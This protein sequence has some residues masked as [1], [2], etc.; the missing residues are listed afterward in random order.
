MARAVLQSDTRRLGGDDTSRASHLKGACQSDQTFSRDFCAEAGLAGGE[1][2]EVCLQLKTEDLPC[3]KGT[4]VVGFARPGALL[5]Y[6]QPHAT[7]DR[8][9]RVEISVCCEMNDV[10]GGRMTPEPG[11]GRLVADG[12]RTPESFATSLASVSAYGSGCGMSPFLDS[13][14]SSPL[15]RLA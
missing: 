12:R 2:D 4:I 15:P 5:R 10:G 6:R 7:A 14:A 9:E 3:L 13:A 8:T 11:F 1:D